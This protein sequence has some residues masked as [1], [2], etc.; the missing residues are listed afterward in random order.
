M[1]PRVGDFK[2]ER[3]RHA[4]VCD[5]PLITRA[6]ARMRSRV[7]GTGRP[8]QDLRATLLELSTECAD[9]RSCGQALEEPWVWAQCEHA[10][11][12]FADFPVEELVAIRLC[13]CPRAAATDLLRPMGQALLELDA[14]RRTRGGSSGSKAQVGLLWED[15]AVDLTAGLAR[16]RA[17][18][19]P[20]G[21]LYSMV[22]LPEAMWKATVEGRVGA[23]MC[24]CGALRGVETEEDCRRELAEAAGPGNG[25]QDV[26]CMLEFD[27]VASA[28]AADVQSMSPTAKQ[29]G[30][31]QIILPP[32]TRGYLE[33]IEEAESGDYRRLR[34]SGLRAVEPLLEVLEA[35]EEAVLA[36]S[37]LVGLHASTPPQE[38]EGFPGVDSA[39]LSGAAGCFQALASAAVVKNP[40]AV[41]VVWKGYWEC[42]FEGVQSWEHFKQGKSGVI[43]VARVAVQD[44]VFATRG[45]LKRALGFESAMNHE[46][47]EE[48]RRR[49]LQ[50]IEEVKRSAVG[51]ARER[52]SSLNLE[53]LTDPEAFLRFLA[54]DPVRAFEAAPAAARAYLMASAAQRVLLFAKLMGLVA[55]AGGLLRGDPEVKAAFDSPF[56]LHEEA[57]GWDDRT[58][59][60]DLEGDQFEAPFLTANR[61]HAAR[62]AAGLLQMQRLQLARTRLLI[63]GGA[64]D[65]GKTTILKEVFGFTHFQAGLS[66]QGQTEQIQFALHPDGDERL[67]PVYAVDT[68][69]FGDGEHIH[70]NDMVRLLV[71]AGTWIPGGVTLLWVMKA[72]RNVRQEADEL[73]RTMATGQTT[74]LVLATHMDKFFEERY[75]EVGPQWRDTILAGVS[76]K[77]PRWEQQRRILMAE[78]KAEVEAGVAAVVGDNHQGIVYTCL[79]GWMA[80][81]DSEDEDEFAQQPPWPWARREL[82]D[83]FDIKG[84][85]E[86]RTWL[87]QRV[88]LEPLRSGPAARSVVQPSD[89]PR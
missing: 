68:P 62:R 42:L 7:L 12:H 74:T 83:F 76:P 86:L 50:E 3:R 36:G 87:D 64:P 4:L 8:R 33:S 45:V 14:L 85:K 88:G 11:G 51:V 58:F 23:A 32:F 79:G 25:K 77:D 6:R 22:R 89:A 52:V 72:G 65:V 21:E 55:M 47:M 82:T 2:A 73:L 59:E 35:P 66:R 40:A 26:L 69:G 18:Q 70:R 30:G 78:L 75:W 31:S 1:P 44:V 20:P 57:L 28:R 71:G 13:A 16:L 24:F 29:H 46:V 10:A 60:E 19:S 41:Q 56:P 81:E 54:H 43:G 39:L 61:E 38:E 5:P 84:R 37:L 67:R 53:T 80:A 27:S 63:A 9:M 49:R 34:I 15:L 17:G 48:E